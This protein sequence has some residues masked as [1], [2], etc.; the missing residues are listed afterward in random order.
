MAWMASKMRRIK[1][2]IDDYVH[3]KI[4]F[5]LLLYAVVT[6][7]ETDQPT[8]QFSNKIADF[9]ACASLFICVYILR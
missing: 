6:A 9:V 3:G 4:L 5:Y 1:H 7:T 2:C 8:I